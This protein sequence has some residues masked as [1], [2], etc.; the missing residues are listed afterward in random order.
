MCKLLITDAKKAIDLLKR[1]MFISK[2]DSIKIVLQKI[3]RQ[4][5]ESEMFR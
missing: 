4:I 3:L 2:T 1:K 5:I